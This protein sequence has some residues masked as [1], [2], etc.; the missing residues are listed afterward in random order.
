MAEQKTKAERV[1]GIVGSIISI[2]GSLVLLDTWVSERK[3]KKL[4]ESKKGQ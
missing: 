1:I 4:F 2:L 3:A